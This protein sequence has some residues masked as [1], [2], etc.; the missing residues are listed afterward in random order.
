[1]YQERAKHQN[2]IEPREVQVDLG[3]CRWLDKDEG[4]LEALFRPRPFSPRRQHLHF[5]ILS[6]TIKILYLVTRVLEETS[7]HRIRR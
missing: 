2:H 4:L 5:T 7:H 1:M 6:T 3:L